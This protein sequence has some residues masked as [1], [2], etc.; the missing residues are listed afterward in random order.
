MIKITEQ[1]NIRCLKCLAC[2]K[3]IIRIGVFYMCN[4][5]YN[6]EFKELTED[7]KTGGI[8]YG[9]GIDPNGKGSETYYHWLQIYLG[10]SDE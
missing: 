5:C 2:P 6:E 1:Y 3:K 10:K 4:N 8:S 9:T 7:I